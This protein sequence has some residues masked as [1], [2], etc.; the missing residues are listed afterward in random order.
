MLRSCTRDPAPTAA[1]ERLNM[2]SPHRRI[3]LLR[4]RVSAGPPF[5]YPLTESHFHL[6]RCNI[7]AA[8]SS[9]NINHRVSTF[10]QSMDPA[11]AQKNICDQY[12]FEGKALLTVNLKELGKNS[13]AA[14]E[15]LRSRLQEAIK[16]KGSRAKLTMTDARVA[17][18]LLQKFLHHSRIEGY[19]VLVI[20]PE[21]IQVRAPA[22]TKVRGG[23]TEEGARPSAWETVPDLW[24]LTPP[25]IVRPGKRSKREAKRVVRGL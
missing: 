1:S 17:K 3:L 23:R 22:K 5:K 25:G 19:R 7:G 12:A 2:S 14:V 24:Y 15:Y 13:A 10:G 8:V 6:S 16:V 11:S 20:N 4:D 9:T 21:M 18:E